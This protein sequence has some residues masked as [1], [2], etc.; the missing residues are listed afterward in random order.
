MRRVPAEPVER[1]S[2]AF[3]PTQGEELYD[4]SL[5]QSEAIAEGDGGPPRAE[6]MSPDLCWIVRRQRQRSR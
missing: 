3:G 6:T 1:S 5:E 2:G 4:E